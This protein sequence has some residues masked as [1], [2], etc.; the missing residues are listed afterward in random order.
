MELM[1]GMLAFFIFIIIIF[2]V[3][4]F[5]FPELV[6]ITGKRAK[7]IQKHQQEVDQDQK[8]HTEP[9]PQGEKKS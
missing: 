4:S 8:A 9:D 2:V 5:L 7:E 3:I 6:G 1:W